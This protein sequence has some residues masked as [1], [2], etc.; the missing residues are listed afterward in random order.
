MRWFIDCFYTT[1]INMPTLV[2]PSVESYDSWLVTHTISIYTAF[3]EPLTFGLSIWSLHSTALEGASSTHFPSEK[4]LDRSSKTSSPWILFPVFFPN[5]QVW[6]LPNHDSWSFPWWFPN[7]TYALSSVVVFYLIYWH[8]LYIH[9]ITSY[10][11]HFMISTPPKS[12]AFC[13]CIATSRRETL[14]RRSSRLDG[15]WWPR[16]R[17]RAEDCRGRHRGGDLERLGENIA[18]IISIHNIYCIYIY[19]IYIYIYT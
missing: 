16:W 7:R 9:N 8:S 17:D 12:A 14:R 13:P 3:L 19:R 6:P 2:L 10:H 4:D 5:G 18:Y 11:L 1:W 15:F